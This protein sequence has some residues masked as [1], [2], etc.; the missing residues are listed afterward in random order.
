MA[1]LEV[2][3]SADGSSWE[4]NFTV[5]GSVDASIT[6][7]STSVANEYIKQ[8]YDCLMIVANLRSDT[9]AYATGLQLRFNND[10]SQACSSTSVLCSSP[11]YTP[12]RD[13]AATAAIVGLQIA[14]DDTTSP[15]GN[16]LFS[17]VRYWIPNYASTANF[18]TAFGEA[19]VE[20]TQTTTT[21]W[22]MTWTT[23][24]YPLTA[25]ITAVTLLPEAGSFMQYSRVTLYGYTGA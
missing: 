16:D 13:A 24:F 25:A 15:N 6:F 9:S 5:D 3:T 12:S 10:S 19:D 14:G 8:T 1:A 4:G 11:S 21:R 22:P 18:T 20:T 17:C 7:G 23:G 2:A